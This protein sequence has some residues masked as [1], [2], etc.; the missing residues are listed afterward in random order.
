MA[1][2]QISV[3]LHNVPGSL[4]KLSGILDNEGIA[5]KAI[6]AASAAEQSV[7]RLVVNDP[8]RAATVLESF[9]FTY[10]ISPVLA[11]EVPLHPGGMSAILKP[12]AENDI[13]VHYLYTTIN[14]FGRETIVILGVDRYEEGKKVLERNWIRLVGEEIYTL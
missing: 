6:L 10:E 13:N 4:L 12:L 7:V 8:R 1:V 9:Q 5:A 11:A 3:S 2:M 14:R